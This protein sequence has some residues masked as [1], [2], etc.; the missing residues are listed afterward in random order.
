MVS[1]QDLGNTAVRNPKLTGNVA[2]TDA[3]L[4]QLDYPE[5]YGVR[6]GP[7]GKEKVG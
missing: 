4:G 2:G 1:G 3:Q 5:P 7:E 6:E